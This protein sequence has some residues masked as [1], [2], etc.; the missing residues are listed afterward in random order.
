MIFLTTGEKIRTLRKKFG[1]RQ[2]ELEDKNMTRAFVSMIE[3]G[4]RGLSRDSAKIIADKLNQKAMS[5]GIKTNIDEDYLLRAPDE[6]AEIY[7]NEKL[8]NSPTNDEID[9]IIKIAEKYK[10][11]KVQA[12]SYKIL[13]DYDFKG[14]SYTNAS[15]NYIL[16]LDLYKDTNDNSSLSYI[17]NKI[18]ECK[19]N[20]SEYKEALSFFNRAEDYAAVNNTLQDKKRCL[21]NIAHVYNKVKEYDKSLD[22][23]DEYLSLCNRE[24]EIEEYM[25][26]QVLK[27]NCYENKG[28]AEKA[29]SIYNILVS[30]FEN[31]ESE[32][33]W[34]V[35]N[36][37]GIIY[38]KE[39]SLDKALECFSLAEKLTKETCIENLSLTYI[40]KSKAYMG[41]RLCQEALKFA[42]KGA[43][44]ALEINNTNLGVK[45]YHSLIDVYNMLGDFGG[46]KNSYIRLLEIIKNNDYY[47]DEMI[48]AYNKLALLYL[49]QNDFEMCKKYLCMVS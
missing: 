17:Y 40:E 48:K 44:L 38:G 43:A 46:L 13:G 36:N 25:N 16:S 39:K 31:K 29:I 27:A 23:I 12:K 2:Q 15:I 35:Y 41:K 1:M 21:Y 33:L 6:D 7:C 20:K 3:T 34:Q 24:D 32:S 4:K 30:E 45:A 14:K 8:N 28:N 9:V 49:E 26:I 18:G 47:K 37:L 5:L 42:N 19:A 10:L 11:T 22:C